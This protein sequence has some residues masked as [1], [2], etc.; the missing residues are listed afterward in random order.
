[1]KKTKAILEIIAF[2]IGGV[3]AAYTF[4]YK[5]LYVPY[6]EPATIVVSSFMEKIDTLNGLQGIRCKINLK[7]NGKNRSYVLS[8]LYNIVGYNIKQSK[9][10]YLDSNYCSWLNTF[11]KSSK[12]LPRFYEYSNGVTIQNGELVENRRW[13][14]PSEEMPFEFI[15]YVPI[16]VYFK[17]VEIA[18]QVYNTKDTS[19]LS[20][21]FFVDKGTCLVKPK[22]LI[23]NKY[24]TD[25][26]TS[27][28]GFNTNGVSVAESFYSCL[29]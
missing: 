10:N 3:W 29:L 23:K 25:T 24:H 5:E 1:M 22:I 8:A 17:E 11:I 18:V 28:E 16:G 26:L 14:D 21:L 15:T 4:F 13:L 7:N 9:L 6:K 20:P 27:A 12:T 19:H 2:F